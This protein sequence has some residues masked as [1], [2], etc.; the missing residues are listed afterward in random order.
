MQKYRKCLYIQHWLRLSENKEKTDIDYVGV[1][2]GVFPVSL[3]FEMYSMS[4]N[5]HA[6]IIKINFHH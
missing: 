1:H 3:D 5:C 2:V 6:E 4:L